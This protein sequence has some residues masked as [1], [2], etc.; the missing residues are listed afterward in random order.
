MAILLNCVKSSSHYSPAYPGF[1][2]GGGILPTPPSLTSVVHT[3]EAV[4][5]RW[6]PVSALAVSRLIGG[7]PERKK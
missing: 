2:F 6:W 4:A 3:F 5:G 7:A 1:L